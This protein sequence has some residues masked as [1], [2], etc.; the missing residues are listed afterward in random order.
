MTNWQ[1]IYERN[2]LAYPNLH[3]KAKAEY[4]AQHRIQGVIHRTPEFMEWMGR[5]IAAMRGETGVAHQ[6]TS[7]GTPQFHNPIP[8]LSSSPPKSNDNSGKIIAAMLLV[9]AVVGFVVVFALANND[10]NGESEGERASRRSA[11][12]AAEDRERKEAELFAE[13][14]SIL[15]EAELGY[16]PERQDF[17]TF[18]DEW[19]DGTPYESSPPIARD[20]ADAIVLS[21]EI[22]NA[23][24]AEMQSTTAIFCQ[25]Y[26]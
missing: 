21:L 1:E 23:T 20:I 10:G 22:A 18:C 4:A 17:V 9:A 2:R 8:V 11:A 3:E 14:M 19:R 6:M 15:I 5:R 7:V 13:A 16:R 26:R 25:Y 24:R 12:S